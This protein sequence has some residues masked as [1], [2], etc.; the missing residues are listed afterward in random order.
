[1]SSA[2]RPDGRVTLVVGATGSGKTSW[3]IRELTAAPR[4]LVWD[5]E[6]TLAARL[7]CRPVRNLRELS[8]ALRA[9]ATDERARIAYQPPAP[10]AGAFDVFALG[11]FAWAG[12]APG[13]ILAEELADVTRP[14]K[15]PEG[16]GMLLRRGRARGAAV[17]AITQRITECD[18]TV[19]GLAAD[20]ICF[21][22]DRPRDRATMAEFMDVDPA[23]I[24]RL[25]TVTGAARPFAEYLHRDRR[26][27][28]LARKRLN[29]GR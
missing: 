6:H 23:D 25:R 12:A 21:R 28:T 26:A 17:Y 16:W 10:S 8:A 14:G 2:R 22:L 29:L 27:G 24:G 20:L 7:R 9:S 11:A 13:A 19:S 4:L 1:M 18:T 3:A 15:A 5:V